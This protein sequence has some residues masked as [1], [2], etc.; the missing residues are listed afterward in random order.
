M[1]A[2]EH[3]QA[4]GL[5]LRRLGLGLGD[6]IIATVVIVR[7]ARAVAVAPGGGNR[8]GGRRKA[9]QQLTARHVGNASRR[10]R[11]AAHLSL[12]RLRLR[13]LHGR[14]LLARG[15]L[16]EPQCDG[17]DVHVLRRALCRRLRLRQRLRLRPRRRNAP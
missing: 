10:R 11:G 3:P 14:M 9:G 12:A 5:P 17:C 7:G 1:S 8:L 13:L 4:H 2:K 16:R 15:V 6:A